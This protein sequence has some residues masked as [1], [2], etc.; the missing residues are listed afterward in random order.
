MKSQELSGSS[1]NITANLVNDY[2]A[3]KKKL[4]L[5]Q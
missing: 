3:R 1:I 2:T 5:K 4:N